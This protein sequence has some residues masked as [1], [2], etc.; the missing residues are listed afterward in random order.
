MGRVQCAGVA[1]LMF[2]MLLSGVTVATAQE[3]QSPALAKRLT[4][5]LAQAKLDSIAA[6]DP[7]DPGVYVAA[8]YYPGAELLVIQGKYS[9]P[10]AMDQMLAQKSYRDI[11]VDLNGAAVAGSKIFVEDL[12]ADGLTMD[13]GHDQ[14][15][16]S[17]YAGTQTVQFDHDWKAQK[18]SEDEY[19]KAFAAADAQY[20]K[21]LT[22][23]LAAVKPA[24]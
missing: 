10:D 12:K 5:A 19:K 4:A 8:L 18:M 7:N 24:S 21:M 15:F 11:Y 17:Y 6:K 16:D 22:L 14:P 13:P 20:S 1:V 23:L 3:A 2:L 9:A